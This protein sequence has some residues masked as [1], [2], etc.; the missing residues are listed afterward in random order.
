MGRNSMELEMERLLVKKL[1]AFVRTPFN[2]NGVEVG[3]LRIAF[4]A[5]AEYVREAT[6]GKFGLQQIQVDCALL[7]TFVQG[8][9]EDD[10]ATVLCS[11]LNEA[12]TSASQ[13]CDDPTLM[14]AALLE[15]MIEEKKRE[16]NLD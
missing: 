2:R 12:V 16:F 9:T 8:F 15:T 14:D 7:S 11:L 4:K 6:F 13:R 3:I 5:L 10:D 1:Q